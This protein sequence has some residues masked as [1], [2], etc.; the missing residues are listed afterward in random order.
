MS[1]ALGASVLLDDGLRQPGLAVLGL[2][3]C[4][5]GAAAGVRHGLIAAAFA[6]LG[7]AGLAALQ[8]SGRLARRAARN[9]WP[10]WP[11]CT[12]W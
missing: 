12:P 11:G 1:L 8:A 10:C 9:R 6:L 2:V 4:L 7:I 5:L 3:V